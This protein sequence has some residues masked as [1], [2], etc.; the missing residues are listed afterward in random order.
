YEGF[1]SVDMNNNK[2]SVDVYNTEYTDKK[3][4]I[5]DKLDLE[6]NYEENM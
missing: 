2:I 6:S 1:M 5:G 3:I 4:V